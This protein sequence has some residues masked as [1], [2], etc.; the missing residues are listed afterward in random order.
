MLLRFRNVFVRVRTWSVPYNRQ[1]QKTFSTFSIP[2]KIVDIAVRQS[3]HY[4]GC[5]SV[6]D[7]IGPVVVPAFD[8]QMCLPSAMKKKCYS[9]G[10]HIAVGGQ[11][12]GL[13]WDPLR[14]MNLSVG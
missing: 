9:A 4:P 11:T 7:Y 5:S 2:S 13:I 12:P 1:T 14:V 6:S 3:L 10:G 8:T